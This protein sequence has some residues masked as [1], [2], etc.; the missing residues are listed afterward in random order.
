L[1]HRQAIVDPVPG[2]TIDRHYAEVEW[3]GYKFDLID[4]GGFEADVEGSPILTQMKNQAAIAIE[5]ADAIIVLFDV[6]SGLMPADRELAEILRKSG[7]K[8]YCAINKVDS[9]R[10]ETLTTDFY[11]FGVETIFPVSA[12]H[13]RGVGELLDRIIGDLKG[14]GFWKERP[15]EA[16]EEGTRIAVVGRPNVGKSSLINKILGQERLA[17]TPEPGTT[18]DAIDTTFEKDG[19]KFVFI[20][21]AGLRRK[22]KIEKSFEYYAVLRTVRAIERADVVVHLLEAGE[23]VDQDAKIAGLAHDRGKAFIV[24]INKWDLVKDKDK[25]TTEIEYELNRI[26]WHVSYA[27]VTFISAVTGE[28]LDELWGLFETVGKEYKKRIP[29]GELNKFFEELKSKHS[30]PI[31]G[32]TPLKLYYIT[33]TYT[34][35]PTFAIFT[36]KERDIPAS[37]QRFILNGLRK[38]FGFTGCPIWVKFRKRKRTVKK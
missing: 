23:I 15:E 28:G 6:K 8:V 31:L 2:V 12:E 13:G 27:P 35:P 14:S 16:K 19:K 10:Q 18:R 17:V 24:A 34:G 7:K 1:G 26:L 11:E 30:A 36:N 29:T 33:Q 9:N 20:D 5:E 25:R 4:T 3:I 21:T 32:A 37:Y 22:S 38:A